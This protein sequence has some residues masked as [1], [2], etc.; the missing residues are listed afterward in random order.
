MAWVGRC[1]GPSP[2]V[3]VRVIR[4]ALPRCSTGLYRGLSEGNA[5]MAGRLRTS[6]DSFVPGVPGRI[7]FVPGAAGDKL[8]NTG[9][10][11]RAVLILSPVSPVKKG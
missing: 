10:G 11:F 4:A 1:L 2:V 9:A 6:V 5:S 7:P 8:F 3:P